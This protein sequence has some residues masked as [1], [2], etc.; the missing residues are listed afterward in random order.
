MW[1]LFLKFLP[2][3]VQAWLTPIK[4]ILIVI[5]ILSFL[6]LCWKIHHD[7]WYDGYNTRNAE[8]EAAAKKAKEEAD[9]KITAL[10]K[11]YEVLYQQLDDIPETE[12]CVGPASSFVLDRMPRPSSSGK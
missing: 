6:G 3:S 5:G 12:G 7:I 9:K 4:L 11:A 1:E 8:F 2:A 10:E